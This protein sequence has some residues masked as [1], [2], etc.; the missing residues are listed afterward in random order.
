MRTDATAHTQEGV[1][2]AVLS[3]EFSSA[4][5]YGCNYPKGRPARSLARRYF[6]LNR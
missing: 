1:P 2:W 5:A 4:Q 6:F 3:S